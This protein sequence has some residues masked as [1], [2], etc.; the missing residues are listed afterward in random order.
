MNILKDTLVEVVSLLPKCF[1]TLY[2]PDVMPDSPALIT[3]V[4]GEKQY[5]YS[6]L[7]FFLFYLNNFIYREG[8]S[9][10]GLMYN[11]WFDFTLLFEKQ[12]SPFGPRIH[13]R[14]V[15]KIIIGIV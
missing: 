8:G 12:L 14:L 9:G 15:K 13:P 1:I 5:A 11:R 4:R 10:R 6:L 3:Y 2:S 7:Y